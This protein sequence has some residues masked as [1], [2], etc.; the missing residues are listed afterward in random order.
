L[1]EIKIW[2][3]RGWC[4]ICRGGFHAEP[5]CGYGHPDRESA[6]AEAQAHWDAIHKV[7]CLVLPEDLEEED[8]A[9]AG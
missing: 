8:G 7:V 3:Y 2:K 5:A 6:A 1:P 4:W 9:R